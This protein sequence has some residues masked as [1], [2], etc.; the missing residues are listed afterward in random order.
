[1]TPSGALWPRRL[2]PPSTAPRVAAALSCPALLPLRLLLVVP[3]VVAALVMAVPM[4]A[5]MRGC[6][7]RM[8]PVRALRSP[9]SFVAIVLVPVSVAPARPPMHRGGLRPALVLIP[10]A[11]AR[12]RRRRLRPGPPAAG[13]RMRWL[14]FVVLLLLLV[15]VFVLILPRLLFI[16][17]RGYRHGGGRCRAVAP[18]I[19]SPARTGL[20]SDSA[21]ILS[22]TILWVHVSSL[23]FDGRAQ[24]GP[25]EAG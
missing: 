3:L 2:G 13:A 5:A 8:R 20:E 15:L 4:P 9:A 22:R 16:H 7:R 12:C 21:K 18:S 25:R 24:N 11:R 14:L 1:M 10:T 17:R 19:L 6:A 23:Q